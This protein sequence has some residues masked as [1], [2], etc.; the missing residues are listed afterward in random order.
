MPSEHSPGQG[1]QSPVLTTPA[2][3]PD[4]ST[5]GQA[6]TTS[7]GREDETVVAL[8]PGMWSVCREMLPQHGWSP[9]GVESYRG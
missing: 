4:S 1:G 7:A 8:P 5:V 3:L 2:G 9:G 6:T